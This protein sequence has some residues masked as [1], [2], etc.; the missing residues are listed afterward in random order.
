MRFYSSYYKYDPRR[1]SKYDDATQT[2]IH[3]KLIREYKAALRALIHASVIS[4][5]E[6]KRR[7]E[8]FLL[9]QF[10]MGLKMA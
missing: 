6:A 3:N 9:G 1:L 5:Y 7:L 10:A 8:A 2:Y 4:P